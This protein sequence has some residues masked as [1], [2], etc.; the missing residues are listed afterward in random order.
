LSEEK[1]SES[2]TCM[3]HVDPKLKNSG[4]DLERIVREYSITKGKIVP[5]GKGG[6]RNDPLKA[7]YIL[8]LAPNFKIAVIE[9]KSYDLS[10]DLGMQQ[11]LRYAEMLELKFAY[12][13][14]GK[15]IEEYEIGRA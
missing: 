14:N 10:H 11:A 15:K 7:D 5:E 9:A 6:R 1:I 2:T 13:T 3:R 8:Q 4:W 12:S